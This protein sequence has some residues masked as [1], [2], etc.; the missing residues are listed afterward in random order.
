MLKDSGFIA[1]PDR[2]A[3]LARRSSLAMAS[4]FNRSTPTT[5][6]PTPS[7]QVRMA[8]AVLDQDTGPSSNRI[9]PE[10]TRLGARIVRYPYIHSHPNELHV[11]LHERVNVLRIEKNGQVMAQNDR[12]ECGY[13][14]EEILAPGLATTPT[15]PARRKGK[16]IH[17]SSAETLASVA[18]STLEFRLDDVIRIERILPDGSAIGRNQR[19]E[20]GMLATKALTTTSSTP[21]LRS[22]YTASPRHNQYPKPVI[23]YRI[24]H[25]HKA[26]I[27]GGLSVQRNE[28]LTVIRIYKNAWAFVH[29]SE[30]QR[31]IVPISILVPCDPKER[32]FEVSLIEPTVLPGTLKSSLV[33]KTLTVTTN[34]GG[35]LSSSSPSPS[36]T[37]DPLRLN[38]GDSFT[39]HEVFEDGWA[40][41][42]SH[43]GTNGFI[44]VAIL[45]QQEMWNRQARQSQASRS[46][47]TRSQT[48]AGTVA[49]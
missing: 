13:L 2:L 27:I 15:P 46:Q 32:P 42:R 12:G 43:R 7:A 47:A 41:G 30:G 4:A 21:T 25:D 8:L 28:T 45:D 36:S 14:P 10:T 22:Q 6:P 38:V 18:S 39:V 35:Q 1:F 24:I 5:K 49:A 33:G 17:R 40:M 19:G 37:A 34:F 11:E 23:Y 3:N 44:P 16:R 29:T 31:G 20:S 26:D 9:L 48:G